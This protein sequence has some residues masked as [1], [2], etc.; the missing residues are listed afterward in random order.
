MSKGMTFAVAA[1]L[2]RWSIIKRRLRKWLL[3]NYRQAHYLQFKNRDCSET[4]NDNTV[5][6]INEAF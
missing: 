1:V 5:F 3:I 2:A 6:L 4:L